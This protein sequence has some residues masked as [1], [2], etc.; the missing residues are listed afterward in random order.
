MALEQASDSV[1]IVDESGQ[2]VDNPDLEN[3]WVEDIA[4]VTEDG[5]I[6]V[7]KRI[8]H[9]YSDDELE[10]IEAQQKQDQLTEQSTAFFLGGVKAQMKQDIKDA[11][12]SGGA[13]PA[14]ASFATLAMPMVAPTA[15][16]SALASVM[17]Y[18]PLYIP[19]GHAYKNCA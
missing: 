6:E 17:K 19:E 10:H 12:S 7:T 9:P 15:K 16:D 3:G 5:T 18:A 8:Y 14:L 1:E 4:L 13:D 11:A 2:P